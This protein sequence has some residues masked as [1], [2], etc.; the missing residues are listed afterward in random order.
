MTARLEIIDIPHWK[1]PFPDED[2]SNALE[3]LEDGKILFFQN[4]TFLLEDSW[5][6][7][8]SP[9]ISDG[10][11]KN[12]SFD[13]VKDGLRGTILRGSDQG[14]LHSMMEVFSAAATRLVFDLFPRYRPN[15]GRGR[16]SYR[17]IEIAGREY[18]R[19]K[20]DKLLHIDAFPSTPTQ[21]SRILRLFSNIDPS[22]KPRVWHIGEP[23]EQFAERLLPARGPSAVPIAWLLV[24]VGATRGRRSAYDQLMLGLHN[25]A[26]RDAAF[27][28][29]AP[30]EEIAFPA[31]SSW[32]C[33]TDEVLHAAVA[34]QYALEQTFYV[35]IEGMAEP[36]KSPLRT[37]ERMTRRKLC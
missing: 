23:F 20:D 8:L 10:R 30:Y 6:V 31:G 17:P 34:G 27:Q 2:Q 33:F 26:K 4:L 35:G 5:H 11:A 21:G 19:L 24:A 25:S 14:L 15:I 1:G 13:P 28:E 7:L 18:S 16:A 12:I 3:S 37:L 36:A 29:S 22:G 9:T 32:L